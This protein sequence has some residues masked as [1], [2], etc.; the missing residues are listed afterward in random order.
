M[1]RKHAEHV[2]RAGSAEPVQPRSAKASAEGFIGGG[3][4]A[5]CGAFD[6][7]VGAGTGTVL[8]VSLEDSGWRKCGGSCKAVSWTLTAVDRISNDGN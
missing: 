7:G 3:G 4:G 2:A 6:D 1:R 8:D 5:L